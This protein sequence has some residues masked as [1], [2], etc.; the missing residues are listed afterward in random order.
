[1]LFDVGVF[2]VAGEVGPFELVFVVVVKLFRA[3]AVAGASTGP[4]S[5]WAVLGIPLMG[6]LGGIGSSGL[7]FCCEG[8]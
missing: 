5:N 2:G 1:M 3:V 4:Q 8:K 6:R 7:L